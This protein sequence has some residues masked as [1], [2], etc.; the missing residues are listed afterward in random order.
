MKSHK[1]VRENELI[2]QD[3]LSF[4]LIALE[5]TQDKSMSLSVSIPY[6]VYNLK[7]RMQ[8]YIKIRL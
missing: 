4:S 3:I 8:Y 1:K 2:L 5:F 6:H 7:A